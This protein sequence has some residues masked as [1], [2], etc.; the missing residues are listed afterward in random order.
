MLLVCQAMLGVTP[1]LAHCPTPS[2][3]TR[4][5]R[6]ARPW[7]E[8]AE[9]GSGRAG[10]RLRVRARIP[11]HCFALPL[12][13]SCKSKGAAGSGSACLGRRSPVGTGG[14]PVGRGGLSLQVWE[15]VDP[16]LRVPKTSLNEALPS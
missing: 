3:F 13:V 15:R 1:G 7:F 16:F 12:G 2:S 10:P 6:L 11:D 4:G 5:T 14:V 9:L 8:T